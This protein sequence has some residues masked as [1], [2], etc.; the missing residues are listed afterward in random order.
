MTGPTPL[1]ASR[2]GLAAA[3]PGVDPSGQLVD[4]A[5]EVAVPAGQGP[6]GV[7]DVGVVGVGD[8]RRPAAARAA[9]SR[10]G[11]RSR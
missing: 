1:I 2:A 6:Q 4:L 8:L 5:G 11:G 9:S 3:D 10:A 7:E